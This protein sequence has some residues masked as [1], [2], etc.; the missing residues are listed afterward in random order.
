[1]DIDTE[2]EPIKKK[3]IAIVSCKSRKQDYIC[4]ADEMYSPSPIYKTQRE[5]CIKA[6]DEYYII[7]SEYG[8]ISP[9]QIIKP[10]SRAIKISWINP[11]KKH[12]IG[13]YKEGI[14]DLIEEQ[15]NWMI[16]KGWIIDFHTSKT[17]YDP[18][19]ENT[20]Q[21]INY[22]KQP[23]GPGAI[24]QKYE[25]GIIMLDTHDLKTCNELLSLKSKKSKE[26]KQWWY[27]HNHK[28]YFGTSGT[29]LSVFKSQNLNSGAMYKVSLKQSPHSRGW[30]IDKS[31]LDK[32]YQTDSGQW[33]IKK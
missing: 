20:K 13:G 31:L 10:Y 33:R 2:Y 26:S 28:P 30:V 16:N 23:V 14:I 1:M 17:Y 21:K 3:R 11:S 19:K 27:H 15:I 5:F 7:S 6:Y 18:L 29:I 32:L 8:I 12:F 9:Q 4:S 24:Q 25:E 22:I